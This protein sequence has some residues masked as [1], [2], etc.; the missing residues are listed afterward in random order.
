MKNQIGDNMKILHINSYF[1]TSGLFSQLYDR[2]V[3]E[4]HELQVYV[5]IANN[6]SEERLSV[7]GD[8]TTV[9]RPFKGYD[10][11]IFHLKHYKILKDLK[12]RYK[13]ESFDIIHAH[14]LFSNGW[15][16]YQLSK[17]KH[18]PYVVAV[19]NADIRTFFKRMPW[20]R[21]MGIQIM[22]HAKKIVFISRNSYQEV[23]NHYIPVNFQEAFIKKTIV[24]PN[25]ID[26]YWHDHIVNEPRQLSTDPLNIVSTGKVMGLKRFTQ[27]ASMVDAYHKQIGP[28]HLHIIGPDWNSNIVKSLEQMPHVTYHGPMAKEAL[29][30]FYR[31]M[32]I[33]VLLSS[34]ETFGL[35][36]VEAMSQ[37][38]PVIYTKGE[39][40]DSFFNDGEVGMSVDKTDQRGFIHALQYIQDN[41]DDIRQSLPDKI[42]QFD[43]D[44]I[45]QE[46]FDLYT[47]ILEE[48]TIE[49]S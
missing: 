44:R 20:L 38:L 34:P 45:H 41:Y 26:Q 48:D 36:Y 18:T 1:S 39:G 25:G 43:W 4:G 22:K 19:R 2:Q 6:F 42:K 3:N 7:S 23:L 14:S 15:L 31:N 28:A 12:E 37:G 35:V 49:K 33:F 24:L 46:Y 8:Y 5:P 9:V 11:F 30:E 13:H 29:V 47:T 27:L 40:F 21:S 17:T 10:R 16:A 32:D